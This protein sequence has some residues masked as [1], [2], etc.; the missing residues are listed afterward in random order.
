[1]DKKVRQVQSALR[2][3]WRANLVELP[4][5][6]AATGAYEAFQLLD[7]RGLS[8]AASPTPNIHPLRA[9]SCT[10]VP[11]TFYTSGWVHVLEDSEINLLLMVACGLGRNPGEESVAIAAD[12]RLLHYGISRDSFGA[13]RMLNRLG[14]LHVEEVGRREDGRAIAYAENGA[15]L[16]R[17]EINRKGLDLPAYPT[18]LSVLDQH[19]Q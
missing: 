8:S 15:M 14:L 19:L 18:L 7:E 11:L 13:H 6:G 1:M 9:E 12:V 5:G 10:A 2:T 4:H 3:L 17:L 16:H